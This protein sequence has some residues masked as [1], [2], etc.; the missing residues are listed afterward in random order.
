MNSSL[1]QFFNFVASL[2][3]S[4]KISIA[5]TIMLVI[6]G[7]AVMFF[8]ANQENYQ[9][10]FSDLSQK[11]GNAILTK[12]K[13]KNIPYKIGA[14]GSVIK[15]PAEKIYELRLFL[16]GQGLPNGGTS[17]FEIFDNPDF[18]TTKFVQQLNYRRAL[19][20]ELARTIN[21]FKEVKAA[22]VFL[23][24]PKKSLFVEQE[25]PVSASIQLDLKT[26]LSS[27]KVQ[28]IVYLVSNAVEGLDADHVSVVDTKGRVIFK[29]NTENNA[30]AFSSKGQFEYRK[31]IEKQIKED[32]QSMLEAV[33][34]IGRAIVRVRAEIDF[35]EIVLN[36]EEYDPFVTAVRSE[37][38]RQE[39]A[40]LTEQA[41][42]TGQTAANQRAGVVPP[43]TQGQ[44]TKSKNSFTKNYE[45]NR[46]IKK[47]VKPA[48]TIN[49]LTVAAV[50][51]GTYT[52]E[53]L[54]DGTEEKKY[55]P[56]S[57]QE[58]E[59]FESLVKNAMGYNADRADQ[60]AVR[61]APFSSSMT[62]AEMVAPVSREKFDPLFFLKKYSRTIANFFMITL[63]FLLVVRPLLKSIKGIS[64][65]AVTQT[66]S[67]PLDSAD[68]QAIAAD[69][70]VQNYK[71][72]ALETTVSDPFKSKEILKT[73][74]SE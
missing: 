30:S 21:N 65:K 71:G 16:S 14:Q 3:V 39:T 50:I 27:S 59:K 66:E 11:D 20:G 52:I 17:G 31:N 58:L 45:I 12:L 53:K 69:P 62:V 36:E 35:N 19:Q 40:G 6:A 47:S 9:V 44:K 54:A 51:D 8:W 37:K 38:V 56:R 41:T 26:S 64:A 48:G 24:I 72:K 22:S 15:V 33:I 73:W 29:G 74:I 42:E 55:I 63:A 34:G 61:S 1:T 68:Y 2:P 60:V 46:I 7:F 57:E 49:R 5:F 4:K 10:L 23:A 32:V 67:Q 13:E 25:K 28:S 43:S 70:A 18:R